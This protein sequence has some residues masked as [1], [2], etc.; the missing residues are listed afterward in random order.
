LLPLLLLLLLLSLLLAAVLPACCPYSLA[1]KITDF[2]KGLAS[3][4]LG[5][6]LR[7]G[8]T[9]IKAGQLSNTRSGLFR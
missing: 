5:S 7:L 9:F 4:L 1:Q 6:I 3:Y 2:V 8:H